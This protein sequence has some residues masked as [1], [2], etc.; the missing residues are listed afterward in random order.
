MENKKT[1]RR[2]M[3]KGMAATAAAMGAG[4]AGANAMN[5]KETKANVT[6]GD[7]SKIAGMKFKDGEV[8][9]GPNR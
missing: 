7:E 1:N 5:S 3:V 6:H 9:F 8:G 4:L 2:K